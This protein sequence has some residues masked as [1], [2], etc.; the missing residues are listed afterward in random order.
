VILVIWAIASV[1]TI[2]FRCGVPQPWTSAEGKCLD[3][4]SVPCLS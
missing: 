3:M 4:V 1:L 2:T